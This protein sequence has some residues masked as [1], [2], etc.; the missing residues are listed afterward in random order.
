MADAD[1]FLVEAERTKNFRGRRQ[2]GNDAHE[3]Q[4][5]HNKCGIRYQRPDC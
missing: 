1:D 4:L 2:E 3:S 5:Y